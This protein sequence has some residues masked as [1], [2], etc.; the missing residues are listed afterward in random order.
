LLGA[1]SGTRKWWTLAVVVTTT[2]MLL[3]DMTIVAVALPSISKALHP[4]FSSLQWIVDA[5]TLMLAAMLLTAGSM[6]DIFGRK[7]VLAVGLVTFTAA[8]VLCAQAPD[9]IV[10]DF[11]RGV[12][13]VGGAI[14][15]ACSLALIV[16]EF[17]AGERGVAFGVYGAVNG[18]S[19]ALGPI[20]GG[21]LV[22]GIGW[23]AIFYL[24]IPIGIA[25]LI[26]LQKKVVNLPGPVSTIDW[27]GLV[28][29]TS[30]FFLAIFATIRGNDDGWTSPL[31]IGCYVAAVVLFVAFVEIEQR[32]REPMFDLGLL[33][34]PT[35]IGASTTAITMSFS[36]LALIFF[37]TTWL[38]SIL[39][40][41]AVNAGLRML[42]FT[43]M[44][45]LVAPLAGRMTTKVSPRI[46]LTLG[47]GLIAVGILTMTRISMGSSWTVIL[48][49]LCLSGIGL[50]LLNPTLAS[51]A[52]AVVPPWRGGM[53][54]GINSTCREGGATAGIAVLGA[55]L[56]QQVR[57]HVNTSLADTFLAPNARSIANT[58]SVGGTQQLLAK[59]PQS[60]R[61]G[62][63]RTAHLSYAAGLRSAFVL[64][65]AA[66]GA[67]AIAAVVL[68][69]ARHV[70]Y[71][72]EDEVSLAAADAGTFP[73]DLLPPR[74][75]T[76]AERTLIIDRPPA[77][78]FAFIE[79]GENNL[80][81]RTRVTDITRDSGDGGVGT[82]YR[83]GERGPL[84]RRIDADFRVT[85][86]EVPR[87]YAY[88]VTTGPARP[89]AVFTLEPLD[90]GRT[91]LSFTLAWTPAGIAHLIAPFVAKG[92]RRELADLDRLKRALETVDG[93]GQYAIEAPT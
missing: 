74:G 69:R 66:A 85:E 8:S 5:Y 78:V 35:F 27:G 41:S 65:A 82:T 62:L 50:G 48:P 71:E 93:Y 3:L 11:A 59:T 39:G 40:Y 73:A 53:A 80:R 87:R 79:R 37:L 24:N 51:T 76:S 10:L 44:V 67:G 57:S 33:R 72:A 42:P 30:A 1:E 83:Q 45:L 77:A 49:G 9:A 28:T 56:Q 81:W 12:Q 20:I 60:L 22:E 21:L 54:S 61:T 32:C 18:V 90:D 64:A 92:M 6:A 7:R 23:Q 13:G 63:E 34:N 38:Q 68:V 31:I 26:V 91:R 4:S 16:Q 2:F 89:R 15:F 17:P 88:E 19:I 14:M 46:T 84:D 47:L 25:A 86:Y 52:V 75:L 58:I 70:R 43:G 55:I 29:F 36:V